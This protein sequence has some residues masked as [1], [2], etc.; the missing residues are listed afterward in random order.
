LIVLSGP[1]GV[2]KSTVVHELLK[3]SH[4]PLRRAV[5]ATTRSP[6][7]GEIAELDYHF[8]SVPQFEKA[9]AEGAMLEHAVVF[10]RDYYGTPRS[11][12]DDYRELGQGVLL[13]IDV[14][15]AAQVRAKYPGDHCSIFLTVESADILRERLEV[16]G[17]EDPERIARRLATAQSEWARAGEFDHRVLNADLATAVKELESIIAEQFI[18]R[19][20]PC[21]TS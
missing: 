12:V 6:R 5:T 8:W 16:R 20:F 14:Q 10:G 9:I 2:G 4:L 3:G 1:S 21:L 7:A 15:G 19:G 13:V 18:Q 17:T 11:E